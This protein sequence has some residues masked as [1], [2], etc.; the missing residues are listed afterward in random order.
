MSSQTKK[1]KRRNVSLENAPSP[2]G[3]SP[4]VD[5]TASHVPASYSETQRVSP[6]SNNS[7]LGHTL[8]TQGAPQP[9]WPT[10]HTEATSPSV[11]RHSRGIGSSREA[12]SGAPTF[13]QILDLSNWT[14]TR[15]QTPSPQ[16]GGPDWPTRAPEIT[17]DGVCRGLKISGELYIYL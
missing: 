8:T 17:N 13:S 12:V 3:F 6:G 11:T 16:C 9:G 4:P 10:Q 14:Q 5:L 15:P 1:R 7:D 2:R